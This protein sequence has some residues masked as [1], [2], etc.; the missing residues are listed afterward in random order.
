MKNYIVISFIIILI[1]CTSIIKTSTRELEAKIFISE[2]KIK[3]LS[4]KK[5]LLLLENNF[6][7]SPQRL[8][9]L[10]RENELLGYSSQD[11]DL[12][13]LEIISLPIYLS[14]MVIISAIIMLN[15]K[16]DKPYIFH[17]LLGILLSVIIYYIN[18]IFNIFGLT[19]KI[20]IYLSVFFPIIFL[21]IISTIGLIR[22]NEK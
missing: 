17:I 4:N 2:E 14:I 7:S 13:L 10:K 12:H 20:P 16:R 19:N 9:D 18:N 15:I 8:F 5:E 21:S 3:T 22:I 6:L 11:V 1:S